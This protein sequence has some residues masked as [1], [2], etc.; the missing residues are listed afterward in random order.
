MNFYG[1]RNKLLVD[2]ALSCPHGRLI[3][4]QNDNDAKEWGDIGS[5]DL[6]PSEIYYKPLINSM[7]LQG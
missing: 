5:W 2:N 7:N 4:V 1:F 6:T 3:I